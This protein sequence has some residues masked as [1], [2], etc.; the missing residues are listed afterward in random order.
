METL[1]ELKREWSQTPAVPEAYDQASINTIVKSRVHKHAKASMQYFWASFALQ[2][3]VYSLLSHVIIKNFSDI[4]III[5]ALA[6]ILLFLPFTVVLMRKFKRFAIADIKGAGMFSIHEY[7]LKQRELLQSFFLFKKRYEL[8]LIP[9]SSAIG[10]LLTFNLYIPGGVGEHLFGTA[11][12]YA[13]TLLSCYLAIRN[14]NKKSFVQPLQQ[15]DM[16]LSEY[17]LS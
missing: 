16:I 4:N 2:I 6:G 8:I 9:L 11:L 17:A 7:I 13:L 15:L 10:V 3:L 12:T 14:E 1:D 5:P